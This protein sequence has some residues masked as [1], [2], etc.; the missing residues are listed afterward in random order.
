[1]G[2]PSFSNILSSAQ[3]LRSYRALPDDLGTWIQLDSSCLSGSKDNN[4]PYKATPKIGNFLKIIIEI[5]SGKFNIAI[6][7][8]HLYCSEFSENGE[9]PYSY[10]TEIPGE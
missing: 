8:G 5:P 3:P 6:E 2:S 1:M 10:V 7:H 4:V 9:F